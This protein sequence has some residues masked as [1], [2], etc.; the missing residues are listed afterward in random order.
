MP[1]TCIKCERYTGIHCEEPDGYG[2]SFLSNLN[3][4][5]LGDQSGTIYLRDMIIRQTNE[6]I[7]ECPVLLNKMKPRELY[8]RLTQ[9]KV[10]SGPDRATTDPI[11]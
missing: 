1:N 4:Y 7:A 5:L 2:E 8:N 6:T 11:N 3:R 10:G 9:Q